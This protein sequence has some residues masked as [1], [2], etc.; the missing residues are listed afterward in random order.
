M[1]LWVLLIGGLGIVVGLA[2]WG[3]RVME[4][5]GKKVTRLTPSRAVAANVGAATTI[6]LA[7]RLG[8]PISTT[9][10]LVG[11]VIGIG[12]AHGID[13]LNLRVIRNIVV[14][15]LVTIPAGAGLAIVCYYLLKV[16][17]AP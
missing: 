8:F 17:L 4:T 6:V 10:T 1:P 14:S 13:Y 7:S 15:W 12:L 11:A 16:V 5:I 9:R 2:T 3:Y